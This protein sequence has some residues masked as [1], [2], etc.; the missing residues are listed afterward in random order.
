MIR[1][2]LIVEGE[3][4]QL[5]YEII[6]KK[7]KPE[8]DIKTFLLYGCDKEKLKKIFK[9]LNKKLQVSIIAELKKV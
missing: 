2:G 6:L 9:I 4:D 1:M 7:I 5:S 8:L 3:G